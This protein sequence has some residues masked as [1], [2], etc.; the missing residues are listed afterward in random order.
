MRAPL[1]RGFSSD[2]L[3]VDL[4][5]GAGGASDGI[6]NAVGRPPDFAINHDPVA[7]AVHQA[8]HPGTRH[9][10]SD[11]FEIDPSTVCGSRRLGLLWASPDCT[12]FSRAKGTK[13]R[14]SKRRALASV[15]IVWIREARPSVVVVENVEEF[16]DWGPL[17][18]DGKPDKAQA[19]KNFRAWCAKIVD[20]GYGLEFRTVVA[21]DHGAPT[22]RKRL[23][24]IARRMGAI[25]W[26]EATHGPGCAEP[27]RVAAECI[28][29]RH[30]AKA[31]RACTASTSRF[32][33]SPPRTAASSRWWRRR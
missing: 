12:H 16:E 32:A 15:V 23:V 14:D 10:L 33:P 18:P 26:P 3:I 1:L 9:V 20:L 4:F 19:G 21:A 25:I 22:L 24:M 7:L 27:W 2:D 11:V 30:P 31:T 6:R 8:N 17:G 13:P 29:W 5:A 28:N